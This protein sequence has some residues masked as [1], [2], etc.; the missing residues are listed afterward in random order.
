MD[1]KTRIFLGSSI[2][3]LE[4]AKYVKKY[5]ENENEFDCSIWNDDIFD[6]NENVLDILLT[7]INSFDYGIM[8]ATKDDNLESRDETFKSI[9][10]NI[11]FEFGLF[12]G[13]LG[14][15][16]SFLLREKGAKLPSDLLGLTIPD[17]EQGGGLESVASLNNRLNHIKKSIQNKNHL[18]ELG[19]LPSTALAIGYYHNF[20]QL[21]AEFLYSKETIEITGTE[22]KE[23]ELNVII[24]KDLD[25]N[26]KKRAILYFR[27]NDLKQIPLKCSNRNFPVYV[28]FDKENE[29]KLSLYD[30]PTTLDG[31]DKCIELYMR[32][33]HLGKTQAQQLLE[34]RELRNFTQT[35]RNLVQNDAFARDIVKI[36]QEI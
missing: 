9:R 20:V 26:V 24:P 11:V 22:F 25:A 10:D 15:S 19:L 27:K 1:N 2:E 16:R 18:G 30:M 29:N 12:L 32:K 3:G 33:G 31:I 5:F 4:V 8:I 17:F 34:E 21:V 35:L 23:F 28:T 14:K 36:T 6:Y 7:T 13:S